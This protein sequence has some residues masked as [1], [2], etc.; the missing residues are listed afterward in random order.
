MQSKKIGLLART[1]S[2]AVGRGDFN[3]AVAA[4]GRSQGR[5][6]SLIKDLTAFFPRDDGRQDLMYEQDFGLSPYRRRYEEARLAVARAKLA[7][8]DRD[9]LLGLLDI[10]LERYPRAVKRLDGAAARNP[11]AYWPQFLHATAIWLHGDRLRTRDYLADALG[12]IDRAIASEPSHLYAY[13][14]RAGLRREMEDVP[15]RLA[16]ARRVSRMDP[17]FVWARTELAEV[18]SEEGHYRHA[19]REDNALIRRFPS[20]AWAWAQRGR[21][22][23]ISGFYQLALRD[24]E[25]AVALDGECGPLYAWRGETLR[26]LGRHDSALADLDA[27]IRKDPGY[28]LAH[29]WRGRIHLLMGRHWDAIRDFNRCLRLESREM[30]AQAWRGEA[31]WKLGEA[32]RAAEDFAAIYPAQPRALWNARLQPRE[33]QE[34]YFLL[35]PGPGGRRQRDFWADLDSGVKAAPGDPWAWA[36]RGACRSEEGFLREGVADL[37]RALQLDPSLAFAAAWRGESI[38]RMGAP[39]RALADLDAAVR[40]DPD[41]LWAWAWAWRGLALKETGRLDA[42]LESFDRATQG[43]SQRFARAHVWRGEVLWALGRRSQAAA[44]F[45]RAFYLDGKCVEARRWC[46]RT[47]AAA[48]GTLP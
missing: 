7:Q 24:F 1:V 11:D 22:R 42:A 32:R 29:A 35:D 18:L 4:I 14:I 5:R 12:A 9:V 43:P 27:S 20:Q 21:I 41:N 44:A 25:K 6:L 40:K 45:Q 28:R 8:R 15:G 34:N 16:D 10:F 47:R 30:L 2:T 37:T 46:A 13:V 23:G 48:L 19:I 33:T 36:F 39:A 38:R 31:W 26:R 3:G 17:R